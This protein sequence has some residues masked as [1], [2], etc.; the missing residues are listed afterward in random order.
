MAVHE[1]RK[2]RESAERARE[3][4]DLHAEALMRA[5]VDDAVNWKA[6]ADDI[7]SL[8]TARRDDLTV[9]Q[10][11]IANAV[12]PRPSPIARACAASTAIV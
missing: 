1:Q 4:I 5:R 6:L 2:E 9:L 10:T 11:P 8:V 3:R 12:R 7:V